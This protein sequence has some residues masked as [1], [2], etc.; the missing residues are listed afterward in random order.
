[1]IELLNRNFYH[2]VTNFSL[3]AL[4]SLILS[5]YSED[6]VCLVR[7]CFLLR[8]TS[9]FFRILPEADFGTAL[10]NWTPPDRCLKSATSAA[11]KDRIFSAV[12]S[13][14]STKGF[15]TTYALGASPVLRPYTRTSGRFWQTAGGHLM[16]GWLQLICF[17]HSLDGRIRPLFVQKRQ[18]VCLS[19]FDKVGRRKVDGFY[20]LLNLDFLLLNPRPLG[21]Y[22]QNLNHF[23]LISSYSC[24]L[25]R[26]Q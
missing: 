26:S 15:R 12:A 17:D 24:M 20:L 16:S 13:D 10:R 6:L 5:L 22:V 25:T 11:T 3:Y 14:A 8:A 18:L 4:V 23:W 19:A 2:E 7:V 1:M 9:S 21:Y